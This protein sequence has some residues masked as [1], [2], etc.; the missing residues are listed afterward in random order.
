MADVRTVQC[1]RWA[2][3]TLFVA[4][5][6]WTDAEDYPWSCLADGLPRPVQ[7]TEVCSVCGRWQGKRDADD[8]SVIRKP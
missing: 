8:P 1:C 6:Y 3:P 7:D 2:E 5:P 4:H